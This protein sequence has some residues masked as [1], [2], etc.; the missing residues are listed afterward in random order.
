MKN[1][2]DEI[3]KEG[4]V[5]IIKPFGPTVA[6]V[7]IPKNLIESLNNYIDKVVED[8]K[9]SNELDY[10]KKLVGDVTQEFVLEKE[11]AKKIGWIDF[12]SK[13]TASWI[14][15]STGKKITKFNL[16]KSWI[17]RQFKSEYNPLH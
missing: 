4:Q 16:I 10:G 3:L 2:E 12:L 9:K 15:F 11:F 14:S 17:V 13:G 8:K 6:M 7:K 5:K 1:E